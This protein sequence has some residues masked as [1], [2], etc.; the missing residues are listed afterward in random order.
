MDLKYSSP[1]LIIEMGHSSVLCKARSATSA[2]ATVKGLFNTTARLLPVEIRQFSHL[3]N[4][5]WN[6]EHYTLEVNGE[7]SPLADHLITED[8]LELKNLS[9][10]RNDFHW[11]LETRLQEGINRIYDYYDSNLESF[12]ISEL[13]NCNIETNYFTDSIHEYASIA[14]VD[15]YTVYQELSMRTKTAGLIR[16]RNKA[17]YDKYTRIINTAT[18]KDELMKIYADALNDAYKKH[19]L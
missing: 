7:I 1:I 17:I 15:V 14:E 16:L 11:L 4:T 13:A 9:I 19:R 3:K 5:M 6:S 8:Y 2:T 12:L 18:T 10:M